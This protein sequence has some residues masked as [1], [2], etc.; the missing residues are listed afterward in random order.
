MIL[1]LLPQVLIFFLVEKWI[2]P[3][4]LEIAK[5]GPKNRRNFRGQK[6]MISKNDRIR[7]SSNTSSYNAVKNNVTRQCCGFNQSL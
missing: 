3:T 5:I 4:R 2:S 6:N 1:W 7:E